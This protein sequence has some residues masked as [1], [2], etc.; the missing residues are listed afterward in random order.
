MFA[1]EPFADVK[2]VPVPT[3]GVTA[4]DPLELKV[5]VRPVA[6]HTPGV[7]LVTDVV[8]SPLVLTTAMYVSPVIPEA[9]RL[10]IVGVVGVACAMETS[11]LE[12]SAAV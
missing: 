10:V 1:G 6:V 4:Q 2:L 7:E 9:G 8:P 12:P 3:R 11:W 5:T